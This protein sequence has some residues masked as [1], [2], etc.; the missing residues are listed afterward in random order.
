MEAIWP[1]WIDLTE[2]TASASDRPY[3]SYCFVRE[4]AEKRLLLLQG[5]SLNEWLVSNSF[6]KIETVA[7][8]LKFDKRNKKKESRNLHRSSLSL[9]NFPFFFLHFSIIF[10]FSIFDIMSSGPISSVTNSTIINFG[11]NHILLTWGFTGIRTRVL[12]HAR[13][14]RY[15]MGQSV[16]CW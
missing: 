3:K 14:I 15:P 2:A 1:V 12:T 16:I 4:A 8:A 5:S 11:I 13:P 7:E 6:R 10:Y 9:F